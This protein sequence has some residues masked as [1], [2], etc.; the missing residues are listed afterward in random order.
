MNNPEHVEI[1]TE[2]GEYSEQEIRMVESIKRAAAFVRE[3]HR[4]MTNAEL[5]ENRKWRD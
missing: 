1:L 2:Y 4:P 3:H 5:G